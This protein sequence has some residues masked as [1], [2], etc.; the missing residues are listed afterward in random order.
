MY[1]KIMGVLLKSIGGLLHA[2][3]TILF[4]SSSTRS[5]VAIPELNKRF[6]SPRA[7]SGIGSQFET[8]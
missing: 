3:K 6:D 5:R 7:E 2:S 4:Y 1:R 8:S